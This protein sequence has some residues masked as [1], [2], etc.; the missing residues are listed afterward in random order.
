[1]GGGGGGRGVLKQVVVQGLGFRGLRK[2]GSRE[3]A[4]LQGHVDLLQ[5]VADGHVLGTVLGQQR[6]L[7]L[8]ASW[9]VKPFISHSACRVYRAHPKTLYARHAYTST[10]SPEAESVP[11]T[12]NPKPCT[13]SYLSIFPPVSL[14]LPQTPTPP[15]S[16][17]SPCKEMHWDV[18]PYADNSSLVGAIVPPTIIP[19]QD[20]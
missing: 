9:S 6:Q 3:L 10:P 20:C 2:P 19:I 5:H 15:R 17:L 8:G 4:R 12:L 16:H 13:S 18:P 7:L 11:Y 14:A 1:M